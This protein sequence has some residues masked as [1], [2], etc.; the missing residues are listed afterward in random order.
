MRLGSRVGV[1]ALHGGLE[2]R[3]A[4][5]AHAISERT[6]ASLYVVSQSERLRWHVPSVRYDPAFSERLAGFLGH[7]DVAVSLHG[8]GRRHLKRTVLVGGA[9]SGLAIDMAERLRT[10]TALN[11]VTGDAIPRGLRGAHPANPVNLPAGGGVQLELSHSCRH[12]P[13]VEPLIDAVSG[14]VTSR[15]GG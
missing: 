14:F 3:T 10:G 15:Q 6:G 9:S 7:V 1:M 13:H 8:F 5:I 4:S 11:V 12:T 2:K